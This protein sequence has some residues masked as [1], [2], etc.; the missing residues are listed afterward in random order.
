MHKTFLFLILLFFSPSL[1]SFDATILVFGPPGSGKGT[2]SQYLK[3][4]YRYNHISAGDLVR[5]EIDKKTAI[6]R[7]IEERV[8]RGEFIDSSIMH[9]LIRCKVLE[10]KDAGR[11][12]IIDGFGR[13]QEDM[14][15]LYTLLTSLDLLNNTFVLF[16]ESPDEVCKER[17]MHRSLCSQCGHVYNTITSPPCLAERCDRC[18]GRLKQRLNDTPLVIEKRLKEYRTFTE[19]N[20]RKGLLFFPSL[21]YRTDKHLEEL[22][23]WYANLADHIHAFQGN[24][25]GFIE[26]FSSQSS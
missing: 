12:F 25:K 9:E 18:S 26:A 23:T 11:P 13:T 2:F 8:K 4:N 14:Q 6:G 7:S 19:G 1:F 5:Q 21:F 15:F 17:I 22:E 16:L 24:A 20:Y 3:E 10:Y